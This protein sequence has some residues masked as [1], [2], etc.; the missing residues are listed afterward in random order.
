MADETNGKEEKAATE[1]PAG[2]EIA[3]GTPILYAN[4]ITVTASFHEVRLLFGKKEK[5]TGRDVDAVV[6]MS[7]QATRQLRDVLDGIL[8]SYEKTFGPIR[9]TQVDRK[10][11]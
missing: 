8:A 9:M 1:R 7:H 2:P 5:D 4:T 3:P 11:H 6:Y 10:E